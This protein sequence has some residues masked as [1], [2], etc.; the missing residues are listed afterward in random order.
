MPLTGDRP[1]G[2]RLAALGGALALLVLLAVVDGGL[3]G[4][5]VAGRVPLALRV[6]VLGLGLTLIAL[7]GRGNGA[8]ADGGA[9]RRELLLVAGIAVAALVVR[10]WRLDALRVLIDEG[11]SIDN[12]FRVD[13]PDTSL[14]RPPSS[15]VTTMLY[16]ALQAWAMRLSEPSLRG[17]RLSSALLGAATVPA[18][19]WLARRLFDRPT[20]LAA[21]VLLAGF[22]PHVHFS[23]VGLP[24]VFDACAGTFALA[25]VAAGL[26]GGGRW[27]WA[28]GGV[29]LGLTHYGFEAGRWF[30]TPLVAAWLAALALLAPARWRGRRGELAVFAAAALLTVLPLYVSLFAAGGAL[31]PRMRTSGLGGGE[32]AALLAD[33]PALGRRLALA[34]GVYLWEPERAEYYGG[35]RALLAPLAAPFALLGVAVCLWRCRTPAVL[36]PL[37]LAA[38]WAANVAMRDP[39]VYARWV[40]VLPALALATACGVRAVAGWVAAAAERRVALLAAALAAGLAAVEVHGYFTHHIA[41]LAAQARAAKPYRDAYDAALRAAALL[42]RGDILIV[43][44]PPIDVHPPRSLLR[45]L[46]DGRDDLRLDVAAP[47]AVDAAYLTA[48]PADGDRVFFV[49][50]ADAATAARLAACFALDGPRPAPAA[51]AADK[52]LDLYLAPAGS[53]RPRCTPGERR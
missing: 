11:N 45:L 51:V 34:A 52:R 22:A 9:T 5:Q 24:H 30:F 37:W 1:F 20:A 49:A 12:L 39:A 36:V 47:A 32:L 2:G 16:P 53:R 18:L 23:R 38:A 50:P 43:S 26:A 13:L 28:V 25:G 4:P 46:R 19:W 42:R 35:D 10:A 21:A 41:R 3:A 33:P 7:A 15:Y 29:A 14:L 40:V 44:D 31:A 27:A 48:L 17:L 6:A 8:P